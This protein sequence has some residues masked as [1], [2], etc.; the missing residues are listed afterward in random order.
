MTSNRSHGILRM[1]FTQSP[2]LL[3]S[4]IA[5]AVRRSQDTLRVQV[6]LG[7][8]QLRDLG[9]EVVEAAVNG[10][11]NAVRLT[12]ENLEVLRQMWRHPHEASVS[13]SVPDSGPFWPSRYR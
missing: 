6:L 10:G 4:V 12:D 7:F 8:A 5:A 2:W 9:F 11:Y 13:S 3:R 1:T